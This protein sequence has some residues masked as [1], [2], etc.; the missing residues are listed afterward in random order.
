MNPVN[1]TGH[2]TS[3]EYKVVNE[4]VVKQCDG[5]DG[6]EDG[7]IV[8]PQ[9]CKPNIAQLDCSQSFANQSAC[10]NTAQI[11]VRHLVRCR[12][13]AH[14]DASDADNVHHLVRLGVDEW[15]VALPWLRGWLGGPGRL[16]CDRRAIWCVH[17]W[18]TRDAGVLREGGAGPGPDYFRYQVLNKTTV[19]SLEVDEPELERLLAIADLTDP[20]QTTAIDPHIQDF[21]SHGKLITYVGLSDTLIPSGSS[22]W[23]WHRVR[24]ALG[25]PEDLDDS[26]RMFAIPGMGHCRGGPGAWCA[27][28]AE[29]EDISLGG[30]TQ[31]V[32]FDA[33]HDMILALIDWVEKGK[34]P[35]HIIGAKYIGDDKRNG[36]A[37]TRK[38]CPYPQEGVYVGGDTDSADS[39]ECRYNA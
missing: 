21:L 22:I 25:F 4:F 6:V 31:S 23:Y 7:L 29:Q 28:Q 5:L 12:D 18:H 14:T 20:G 3:A 13:A 16:L 9:R 15:H 2:L 32:S 8:N 27:G 19:G 30:A 1:T 11:E 37:F 10:L 36:T 34:A 26:Y 33:S 24:Q 39:F 17:L 35:D 38:L